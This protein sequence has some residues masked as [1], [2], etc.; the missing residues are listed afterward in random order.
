MSFVL[1]GIVTFDSLTPT[2]QTSTF[3]RPSS[4]DD[5]YIFVLAT[6]STGLELDMEATEAFWQC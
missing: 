2:V 5:I 3:Y 6:V 1:C 4:F